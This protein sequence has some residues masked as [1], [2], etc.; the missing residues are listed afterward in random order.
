MWHD[1]FIWGRGGSVGE[2]WWWGCDPLKGVWHSYVTWLI[3]MRQEAITHYMTL[4]VVTWL[5]HT[6]H[7]SFMCVTW[8]IHMC[9]MTHSYVWHDSFICVTWL[10]HTWHDSC[11]RDMTRVYVTWLIRTWYLAHAYV[12]WRIHMCHDSC[13]GDTAHSYGNDSF[14]HDMVRTYMGWLRWVGSLK[15]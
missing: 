1:S 7:D 14:I 8:L 5:V 9:D 6:W 2:S 12:T 11:I 3:H 13:I 4:S 15:S 10:I